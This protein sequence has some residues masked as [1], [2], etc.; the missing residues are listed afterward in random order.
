MTASL[1][2][3]R[4]TYSGLLA[5]AAVALLAAGCSSASSSSSSAQS[6]GVTSTFA[7]AA[8]PSGSWPYPNGDLANTRD[9][10]GSTITSANV[11]QLKEAWTFKLAGQGATNVEGA[12]SLA[13]NP[14]VADGVVYMQDLECN[15]YAISLAT[16][17]LKWEYQVNTPVKTGPGPDGVAVAD[18]RVYG[19]TPTAAFALNAATGKPAWT[20]SSLLSSGQGTFEMQPQATGGRVYLS[21]AYGPAPGGGVLMALNASNGALLW[22]F[23]TVTGPAPGVQALGLGAGGAWE[24][25]L[26]GGDGTVTFGIGNPYQ[27][28]GSAISQP[29]RMLYTD[30]EVTLDAATG[31]LRWYYQAVPNDFKDYD[32]QASP[33]AATVGGVPVI[34]G[35][36]KMG[37]VYAMN[38]LT[39]ALL[40]KTPVG[41]HN[42]HDDDG[43]LLLEHKIT[44][45][46]PYVI[47]PGSYGGILANMALADG[48]V[49]VETINLPLKISSLK[50]VDADASAGVGVSGE[51]EALSLATGKVEWATKV[52]SFPL[53]DTTVVNNLVVTTLLSGELIALNRSTGA[54]VYQ[55]KLPA[56]TNAPIAVAGNAVI[57]PA[58]APLK[59]Q[60][61]RGGVP[62]VVAYT[63]P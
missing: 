16:G 38:A 15:V 31:K 25:P 41:E 9:A 27:S 20:D 57:V 62:Q 22:K 32:M 23:N 42:G 40:W 2:Q 33:I 45:T 54:V 30:S 59:T 61:V 49:Y 4:R 26:V 12:G 55:Q 13:A 8:A 37:D 3:H 63:V 10:T 18:G 48:T 24:T 7:G 56:E 36:G 17:K 60:T 53:G 51:V 50:S 6:T 46:P 35:G 5:M 44:V 34:I 28:L 21:T 1:Y 43:L 52:A 11:S 39:G 14:V 19:E 29:A 47:A 58:G